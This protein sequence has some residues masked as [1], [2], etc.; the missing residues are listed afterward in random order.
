MTPTDKAADT[1]AAVSGGAATTLTIF[2]IT[3]GDMYAILGI[4]FL[5]V[6][7]AWWI[8]NRIKERRSGSTG[9]SDNQSIR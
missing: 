7:I 4:T 8:R 2:G 1:L 3:L 5:V 9:G 6:Q